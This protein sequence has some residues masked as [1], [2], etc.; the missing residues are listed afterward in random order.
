MYSF[1]HVCIHSY[2]YIHSY[3]L[4][5]IHTCIN[6]YKYE[7]KHVCMSKEQFSWP[8]QAFID[9]MYDNHVMNMYELCTKHIFVTLHTANQCQLIPFQCLIV[10]HLG[11]YFLFSLELLERQ[12]CFSRKRYETQ[13]SLTS[14]T[15]PVV[16]LR[17][18][19]LFLLS[20]NGWPKIRLVLS[21]INYQIGIYIYMNRNW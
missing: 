5:F 19:F 14:L 16:Q 3:I 8:K 12:A 1:I 4:V 15:L 7:W 10:T 9:C 18:L 21:W 20:T 2:M 17:E 6:G 11:Q 13:P